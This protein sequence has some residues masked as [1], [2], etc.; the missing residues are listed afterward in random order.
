MKFF[1]SCVVFLFSGKR[2]QGEMRGD[3]KIR[4]IY[5]STM[6][7]TRENPFKKICAF[8]DL[9]CFPKE[10][11]WRKSS[12]ISGSDFFRICVSK[13]KKKTFNL[14]QISHFASMQLTIFLTDQEAYNSFL[15]FLDATFTVSGTLSS[16]FSQTS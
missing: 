4:K 5:M 16:P 12:F 6:Q 2:G 1:R 14:F 11:F 8:S 15:K 9:V 3:T 13:K 7:V 10:N